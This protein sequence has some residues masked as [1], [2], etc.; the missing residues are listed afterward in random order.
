M[1]QILTD[2]GLHVKPFT[3]LDKDLLSPS[4]DSLFTRV[5]GIMV[6]MVEVKSKKSSQT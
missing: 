4:N 2:W 6:L 1:L 3:Q 5:C